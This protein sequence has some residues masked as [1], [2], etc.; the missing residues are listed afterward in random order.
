MKF[1]PFSTHKLGINRL[2]VNQACIKHKD[3]LND[4]YIFCYVRKTKWFKRNKQYD[5]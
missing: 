1:T 4:E 2:D 5:W 3:I